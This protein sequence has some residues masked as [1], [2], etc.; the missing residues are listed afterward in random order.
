MTETI[1][2]KLQ[3]AEFWAF[4]VYA[5]IDELSADELIKDKARLAYLL[6]YELLHKCPK[7]KI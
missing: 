1:K 3:N 5:H 7:D 4:E 6:L 2:D